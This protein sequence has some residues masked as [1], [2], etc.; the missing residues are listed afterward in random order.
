MKRWI[1]C[2]L[3]SVVLIGCSFAQAGSY[4]DFFKAVRQDDE[5]TVRTLLMRGFDLNDPD[6][7]GQLALILAMQLDSARVVPTLLSHPGLKVDNTNRAGETALMIAVL[8]GQRPWAEELLRRGAQVNRQGWTPLHYAATGPSKPLVELLLERGAEL[9]AR[10]PNGTTPLMM[11]ARYGSED[12]ALLLLARGADPRRHNDA[13]L[14]A[15]DFARMGG[16]E[17]L[18]ARLGSPGPR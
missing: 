11:A 6:E 8:R 12:S 3:C 15:A 10:S 13:G 17:S 16:R 18:A 9:E 14:S 5:G 1:Q 4:E 7:N 2:L